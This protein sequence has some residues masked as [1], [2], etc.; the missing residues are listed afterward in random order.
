M[1]AKD[2]LKSIKSA[3]QNLGKPGIVSADYGSVGTSLFSGVLDV[4]FNSDLTDQC[5]IEVFD[6]MRKGDGTV[7]GILEALKTPL[8]SAKHFIKEGDKS[9]EQKRLAEFVRIALFEKLPYKKFFRE[10]LTCFDFGFSLFEKIFTIDEHGFVWWKRFAPRVQSSLYKWEMQSNPKWLDG[11]P[12]GITQQL[13][14]NTD[15]ARKKDTQPEIPWD[16]LIHFAVRQE[17]NNFAGVSILRNAY[18]HWFYKDTLYKI[19]GI[20]AERFGV[21]V[22]T[23][24]HKKGL[25]PEA[26]ENLEEMLEN[27]RANEQAFARYE[28]GIELGILMPEGD[29]KA[30]AIDKAIAHHDRKIYDSILAGFLNLTTGEGGSNALSEDHSAFFMRA[31]RGYADAYTE[32]MNAHIREL[33]DMNFQNVEVYPT[34]EIENIG[35]MKLEPQVKSMALA[36]EKGYVTPT[37]EDEVAV[38]EMLSLPSKSIEEIEEEKEEREEKA[39]QIREEQAK[40]EKEDKEPEKEDDDQKKKEEIDNPKKEED[41]ALAEPQKKKPRPTPRE[42]SFMA[43][44]TDFERFLESEYLKAEKIVERAEDKYRRTL[45]AIYEAADTERIDGVQVLA[46]TKANLKRVKEAEKIIDTI[47]EK[48]LTDKLIDSP[49]QKNLFDKTRKM[50]LANLKADRKLLQEVEVNEAMFN[51]FVAGYISNVKGVIFNDPR[52]IKENVVLNFGSQ[53]SIDLAVRQAGQLKF[54]RNVLRLSTITHARSAYTALLVDENAKSGFVF[55]KVLVPRNKMRDLNPSGS[56]A[57]VLF[58]I[59]T[60]AQLNKRANENTDGKNSNAARGLGLH[61]G[62]FEY[63]YAIESDR[64]DEEIEIAKEQRRDFAEQNN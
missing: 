37:S 6:R 33:I 36:V 20:S 1:A 12:S 15:D 26:K 46:N 39:N 51:S 23:A 47:T 17:G 14:G 49:F 53:T 9:E 21:G 19:Q 24:K 3:F 56:T 22:P 58:G 48:L 10:S 52:R 30:D 64:L 27:I 18:K 31:E 62:S 61:H 32:V 38:R 35:D 25:S 34:L 2:V 59:F 41:K 16:K 45:I 60:I 5:G 29:P 13:P 42:R 8:I 57:A 43:Q 28:D 40:A 44:I 4:E 63:L 54:N 7:G 50:A 55:H 11:H